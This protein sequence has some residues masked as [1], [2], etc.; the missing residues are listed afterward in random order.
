ML[1]LTYQTTCDT[2]GPGTSTQDPGSYEF[3]V[4]GS[5]LYL[6]DGSAHVSRLHLVDPGG[7]CAGDGAFDCYVSN[8]SCDSQENMPVTGLSCTFN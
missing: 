6:R 2:Q 5:D 7:V 4:Q 1:S 3:V 8:C